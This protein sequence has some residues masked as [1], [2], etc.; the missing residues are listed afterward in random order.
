MLHNVVLPIPLRPITRDRL[1]AH[2][3][4]HA[5]EYPRGAVAGTQIV[6]VEQA[7]THSTASSQIDVADDRAATDL[8]GRPDGDH[9]T[10]GHDHHS[11]RH[12]Q[13]NVHVVLDEQQRH[14]A[15]ERFEQ[16]DQSLVSPRDNP[17]AGSSSIIK[18]G[19]VTIAI[20]TSSWRCW[21]WERSPTREST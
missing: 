2:A 3:E 20:P 14:A 17:E 21:P 9:Q 4:R 15:G 6:N 13:G 5:V 7:V 1:D 19:S 16:F 8:V 10:V 11:T 12:P 18:S